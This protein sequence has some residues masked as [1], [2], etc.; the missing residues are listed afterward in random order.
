MVIGDE[1]TKIQLLMALAVVFIL[2]LGCG[3]DDE[4]IVEPDT[5]TGELD[6]SA[7]EPDVTEKPIPVIA[8]GS[9]RGAVEKIE[10]ISVT[11][12]VLQNGSAVASTTVD[13]GGN[14]RIDNIAPGIYTVEIVAKGYKADKK[15]VQVSADG[16][17]SLDRVK[18]EMLDIPVSHIQGTLSDRLKGSPLNGVR[19]RLIDAAGNSREVLTTQTGAFA[20]ENV[21]ADQ[22]F[23]VIVQLDGFEK[24]EFFVDPIQAGETTMLEIE[25]DASLLIRGLVLD[26]VTKKPVVNVRVQ[27]TDEAGVTLE[28]LTTA[29]GAFEFEAIIPKLQLTITIESDEHEKLEVPVGPVE[30]GTV[31]F[32]LQLAPLNPEQLPEGDGLAVG[33]KAPDF[34]LSDTD[35]KRIAL[36][37]YAGKKKVVLM[38]YRGA[39]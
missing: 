1:L 39:W 25:L 31:Q 30:G 9:L 19:V 23:T 15:T 33:L 13:A 6:T 17:A 27:L 20:F 28:T 14:Y 8:T 37:D 3:S 7:G 35:G 11:V 18:L 2:C 5:S 24:K 16:I 10:G 22:R 32:D 36:A 29:L 21:P 26:Q 12:H 34:N 38:F 4:S